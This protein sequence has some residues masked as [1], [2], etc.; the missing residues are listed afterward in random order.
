MKTNPNHP[1][2]LYELGDLLASGQ[3]TEA[4]AKYFVQALKLDPLMIEPRFALEKIYTD[5]GQY[6]KSIEQLTAILKNHPDQSTAH[7]RLAQVYRK[8]GRVEDSQRELALFN[9]SRQQPRPPQKESSAV[10]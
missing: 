8:M 10:R 5:G 9:R 6:R 3:D 7:Y 4:A 2:A 1:Q